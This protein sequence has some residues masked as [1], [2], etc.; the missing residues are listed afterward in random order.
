MSRFA[1]FVLLMVF[2]LSVIGC[3]PRAEPTTREPTDKERLQGVWAVESVECGVELSPQ[4]RQRMMDSRLH[5]K[6]N[7]C[8]MGEG[9]NWE[10]FNFATDDG[11]TPK[12]LRVEEAS[13]DGKEKQSKGIPKAARVRGWIYKFEDDKLVL[14]FLRGN[15]SASVPRPADFKAEA[16]QNVMTLRLVKTKEEPKT[17][18]DAP[19]GGKK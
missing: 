19:A 7:R 16:G 8:A 14:A 10:F 15:D 11:T 12:G 6:E 18:R 3:G 9:D 2:V 17:T 13:A 1:A 5:F 4:D